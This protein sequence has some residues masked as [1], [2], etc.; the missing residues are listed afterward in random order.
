VNIPDRRENELSNLGFIPLVHYKNTNSAVFYSA[1][2]VQK[3]PRYQGDDDQ[4]NAELTARLPHVM[5]TA[6]FAHCLKVMARSRIGG[7][8]QASDCE[9]WL[10]DWISKYVNVNP[11]VSETIKA[12]RPL[13][14][15]RIEVREIPSQPGAFNAVALLEPWMQMEELTASLRMVMHIPKSNTN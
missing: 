3:P 5:A 13:R 8:S 1:Q 4:A 10:N 7:F 11:N 12:E 14:S 9:R 6:R 15:A 2:T